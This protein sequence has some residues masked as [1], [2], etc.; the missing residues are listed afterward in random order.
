M[1]EYVSIL[2]LG[3]LLIL[4]QAAL[5]ADKSVI[6]GFHKKP[7]HHERLLIQNKK[8][9]IK[10]SFNLIKAMSVILSEEEIE[11]MKQE[12][13]VAYIEENGIF[14]TAGEYAEAWGVSHIGAYSAHANGNKG[15][16][17]KIA[18]IDTGIGEMDRDTGIHTI[19]EDLDN[20]Y[21][22]GYDFVF[23]D[24]VP[25]DET[26][27]SHG[28][29]VAGIIAA[30]ENGTGVV[31][32]APEAE[33]Y[34]VRVLDGAGFGLLEWIIAGIEWAVEHDMHIANLSLEGPDFQSLQDACDSAYEAGV[35]LVAAGGNTNGGAVKYPGGYDS[36]I[37]VTATDANN[38]K[39]YFS[40]L[41]PELEL[42]APGD[43]IPSTLKNGGY[44][45]LDGT[46]QAAP[47]VAGTA[48]LFFLT[49]P[50]DENENG[51]IH[52]EVRVMLRETAIDLGDEGFDTTFGFGLVN[53]SALYCEGDFDCDGDVDGIDASSI[54]DDFG[55]S[56]YLDPC[57]DQIPCYGD[58]DCDS[59]VD[60]SDA[61]LFKADFGRGVYENP[62]PSCAWQEWC[63]YP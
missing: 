23:G 7:G 33:I 35:L 30:E 39:A 61:T 28:T 29:H 4:P 58:F 57:T 32:V 22:G 10:R 41:G 31:G 50:P 63:N 45:E 60:G 21:V 59:D 17:I 24:E 54:K 12:E 55:R 47:H 27:N 3:I 8:G 20:N 37:A 18:V 51:L 16:G 48:A 19:P 25:N 52:D 53:V 13:N 49:D 40:P 6:I 9:K 26:T 56:Q 44:G 43:N 1:K 46:S 2:T 5:S 11:K 34:A 62:C 38:N 36:V 14:T 42:S 15:D